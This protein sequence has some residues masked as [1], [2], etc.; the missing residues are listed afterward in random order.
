MMRFPPAVSP[1]LWPAPMH[2]SLSE[3]SAAALPNEH[4]QDW[5]QTERSLRGKGRERK[6]R[7]FSV[8]RNLFQA[9]ATFSQILSETLLIPAINIYKAEVS[10]FVTNVTTLQAKVLTLR[11]FFFM[12]PAF[13]VD[14]Y[15]KCMKALKCEIKTDLGEILITYCYVNIRRKAPKNKKV[16]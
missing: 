3:Y 7:C 1:H 11:G 6:K 12:L 2:L 14:T 13:I 15:L 10:F 5:R 8:Q 9:S 4:P 16:R